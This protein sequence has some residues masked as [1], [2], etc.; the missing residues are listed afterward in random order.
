MSEP[1]VV[2]VRDARWVTCEGFGAGTTFE[3]RDDRFEQVGIN[4]RVLGRGDKASMYHGETAQ[5]DFLVLA[6]ECMLIVEGEE[7]RLK[8]WDFVHCPP[9][10]EH[11]F[12]G[13]GDEPCILVMVGARA[14]GRTYHYPVCEAAIGHGAGVETAT[15]SPDEAYANAAPLV[16]GHPSN[17]GDLPWS[18]RN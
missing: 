12:V 6:G 18:G 7:R 8:A 2:N 1:F 13:A 4:I 5:E 14:P 15:D 16:P 9:G 17:W 3:H 10:T 11:A